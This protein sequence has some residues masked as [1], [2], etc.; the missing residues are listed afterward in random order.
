MNTISDLRSTLGNHADDVD[1]MAHVDRL[2]QVQGRVRVVRRRRRAT[3]AGLAAAIVAVV[4]GVTL[5]PRHHEPTPTDR[6]LGGHVAPKTMTSLGYTYAFDRGVEGDGLAELRLP[7]SDEPR[8]VSWATDDDSADLD[9]PEDPNGR[10]QELGRV[11]SSATEFDDFHFVDPGSPARFEIT[12]SGR[13]ALA[14]YELAG[15]APGVTTDGITWREQVE[16]RSLIVG[17]H[18]H[19]GQD[20]YSVTFTMPEGGFV[21]SDYCQGIPEGLYALT[22]VNGRLVDLNDDC[23]APVGFDPAGEGWFRALNVNGA[24]ESGDPITVRSF[25]ARTDTADAAPVD[26]PDA[27]LGIAV[28]TANGTTDWDPATADQPTRE[29][30]GHSYRRIDTKIAHG[31]KSLDISIPRDRGPILWTMTSDLE[32][33]AS[34]WIAFDGSDADLSRSTVAGM[35]GGVVWPQQARTVGLTMFGTPQPDDIWAVHLYERID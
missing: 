29:Y 32:R 12:G 8:L 11:L 20:D 19:Q 34:W 35:T 1:G 30:E 6:D 13:V 27:R 7:A 25:V 4:G 9:L 5:L 28:Y 16:G 33:N 24:L 31:D 15:A 18:G 21:I 17:R 23:E 10:G 26:A 3:V 2:S 22:T 14:V